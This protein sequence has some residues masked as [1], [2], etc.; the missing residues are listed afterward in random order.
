MKPNFWFGAAVLG[1]VAAVMTPMILL[2]AGGNG[3]GFDAVV[4]GIESRYNVHA[5]RIPFMGLVSGIAGFATRGGVRGL[6][7][8]EIEHLEGPVDGAEFNALVEQ[9]VGQGWQRMIRETTHHRAIKDGDATRDEQTLIYVRPDG[10]RVAM[11]IVD[12]D[13]H[14]LNIVQVSVKPDQLSRQVAEHHHGDHHDSEE[15][16]DKKDGD[17]KDGDNGGD[18]E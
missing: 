14:E 7:V 16:G 17:K 5:T 18:S 4:R 11:L 1:C 13:A 12:L 6:H 9:R 3:G 2:A 10:S 15:N 8:A